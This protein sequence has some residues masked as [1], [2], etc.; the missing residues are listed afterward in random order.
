MCSSDLTP[1]TI[2]VIKRELIEQQ[3]AQTLTEAMRNAPGVGAFFLG[4]NGSTNTGDAIYMRGFD[5]SSSIFVD[6]VRDM[7]SIS[8]DLFNIE[9]IDVLK[10]NAGTDSG[11]SAPT[12]SINLSSKQANMENATS[13][14]LSVGNEIGSTRLNSSHT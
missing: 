13:V 4:E 2:T 7:G 1:Q 5:T 12:G 14:N 3:G 8:R 9:Q 11:R 6:G 10:G